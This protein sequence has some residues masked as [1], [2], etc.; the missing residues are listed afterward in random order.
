MSHN[1]ISGDRIATKPS[2]AY[3]KHYDAIFRKKDKSLWDGYKQNPESGTSEDI[4]KSVK[5]TRKQVAKDAAMFRRL[6]VL[7]S[8][9]CP[10]CDVVVVDEIQP[11][12]A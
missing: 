5:E 8:E 9:S 10:M 2:K 6:A 12:K 3:S 11:T 7:E 1:D 4:R